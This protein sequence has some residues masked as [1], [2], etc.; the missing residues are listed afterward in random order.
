MLNL[1][2]ISTNVIEIY[3]QNLVFDQISL[4]EATEIHS[5]HPQKH[6]IE[7]IPAYGANIRIYYHIQ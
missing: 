3:I 5:Y 7:T 2:Q 4:Y 6:W 1:I